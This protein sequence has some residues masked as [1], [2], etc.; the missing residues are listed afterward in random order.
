MTSGSHFHFLGLAP[1][2]HRLYDTHTN[3]HPPI[4]I[5]M[6]IRRYQYAALAPSTRRTYA[7]A[8]S[9]W[10][11][12]SNSV[13]ANPWLHQNES[14]HSPQ[15]LRYARH[16]YER[17]KHPN[18]AA[19]ILSKISAIAWYHK[20]TRNITV[21]LSPRHKIDVDGMARARLT[22]RRSDPASPAMLRSYYR[23]VKPTSRRDNAIWGSIVLAFFFCMRASEYASTPS[24]TGHHVRQ[25]DIQ[26][27][28]KRGNIART[29]KEA[30]SVHIFLSGIC[31]HLLSK[32][33]DRSNG[34]RLHQITLSIRQPR[35]LPG[36]RCVAPASYWQGDPSQPHR[37]T[38]C[39]L[40]QG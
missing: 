16:L 33:Q 1:T 10:T 36:H 15:L 27:Q 28:D 7:R 13:R 37:P 34:T 5:P 18:G 32:Q 2:C 23:A 24:K 25:K 31:P 39:L 21:G 30:E 11:Q 19:A 8:W 14:V 40:Y 3:A 29:L 35:P 9:G 12:W 17:K 26:F 22:D 20:A 6:R 4:P 38:L